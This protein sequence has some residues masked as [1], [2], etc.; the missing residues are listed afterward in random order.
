MIAW[1]YADSDGEDYGQ[2][3]VLEFS[4]QELVYGPRQIEARIDQDPLISQQLSLWN[5]RGS[6][7]IRGNL[8]VIPID[9]GLIYVEPVFL[10]AESG[11]LP[12]LKRIIV[13]HSSQI[14]MR[15]TLSEALAEVFSGQAPEMAG[16]AEEP[17][18]A[19]PGDNVAA[20]ARSAQAHYD[21]AQICLTEGDWACYGREQAALQADLQALVQLTTAGE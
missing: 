12:E 5:Q 3:G 20:L 6:Q 1:L 21:A 18:E 11:R 4:K 17:A 19:V 13:A 8:M 15:S 9:G 7:V 14:A 10:Q 16:P 2:M